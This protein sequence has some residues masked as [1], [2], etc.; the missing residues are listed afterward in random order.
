MNEQLRTKGKRRRLRNLRKVSTIAGLKSSSKEHGRALCFQLEA[1]VPPI[2]LD[3]LPSLMA[4]IV[5]G[6]SPAF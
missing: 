6:L 3:Q 2:I 4:L 5:T 1:L